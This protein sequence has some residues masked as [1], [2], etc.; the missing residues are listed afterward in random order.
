MTKLAR[1]GH[2]AAAS[3]L[4]PSLALLA[5]SLLLLGFAFLPASGFAAPPEGAEAEVA[6]SPVS[7]PKTTAGAESLPQQVDVHN[8]GD[9][10]TWVEKTMIDGTDGASFKVT[11][12]DCNTLEPGAHCSIW[13]AF[14]PSEAGQKEATLNLHMGDGSDA[15]L[16]LTA[17]AVPVQLA[18]TPGFHDFGVAQVNQGDASTGFQLTNAGE[19]PA[20]LGGIGIGGEYEFFWTSGKD[21]QNGRWLQPGESC[22]L[23]VHFNPRD[24]VAYSAQVQAYSHGQT[25]SAA[26]SGE[27]G[28]PVVEAAPNPFEFG[29]APV[30]TVGAPQAIVVTNSGNLPGGFFIAIVAGG[31]VGSFQLLDE[32]CTEEPLAPGASCVAHIRFAPQRTGPLAARLALFGESEGGTMVKL[33]GEGLA[34]L[35]VVPSAPGSATTSGSGPAAAPQD[36]SAPPASPR[37]RGRHRR[38]ARGAAIGSAVASRPH[39][40]AVRVSAAPR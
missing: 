7:F 32:N 4:V 34:P 39:R 31:D 21:C 14:M 16:P 36:Q 13:I 37:R 33:R 40:P 11:N 20:Q 17:T 15:T 27:G 25:F 10:G 28:R 3:I 29:A 23:E 30:G 22:F 5:L 6:I 38:F 26:L 19:A 8:D 18:F 12:T 35:P 9:A 2:E 1:R 24:T